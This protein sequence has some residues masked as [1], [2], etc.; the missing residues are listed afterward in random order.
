MKT[1]LF[2][3][4]ALLSIFAMG[5]K[6]IDVT[7]P[8]SIGA[9]AGTYSGQFVSVH[10]NTPKN[11]TVK[12]NIQLALYPSYTFQVVGD[13]STVHA[14]S[15]GSFALNSGTTTIQFFDVT[16]PVSGT[17]T[18]IH[19]SGQYQYTFD[20]I[21]LDMTGANSANTTTYTYTLTKIN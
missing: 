6:K 10:I 12:A 1:K 13:T 21:Y 15:K 4:L 5:C 16:F 17:P 18:K 8:P 9:L 11:D 14:G 19:L 2:C 3:L 7:K 20:Q